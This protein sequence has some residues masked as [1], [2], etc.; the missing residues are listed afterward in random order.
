MADHVQPFRILVGDDGQLG[1]PL[2][3]VRGIDHLAVDLAGQRRLGQA[4]ADAGGNLGY[5]DRAVEFADG[6]I[7]K[8]D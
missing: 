1:V 2:D 3:Q 6:T 4:G 8:A 7:G 5:G